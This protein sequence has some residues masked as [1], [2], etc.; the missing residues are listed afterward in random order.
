[1]RPRYLLFVSELGTDCG[2]ADRIALRTGFKVALA[3]RGFTALVNEGC[4]CLPVANGGCVLGTLFPRHGSA[5]RLD[6]IEPAAARAI[7]ES[8]GDDLVRKFWGGYVAAINGPNSVR[9]IRDV[10][11]ALPCY[12]ANGD[13]YLVFA[14]DA[15]LLTDTG[16]ARADIDWSALA[17]HFYAA[18][19]PAASTVIADVRELLPGFA[20]DFP[21]AIAGQRPCWSPWDHVDAD[22][23]DL[24]L[25]AEHLERTVT[26]CAAAWTSGRG[27]LLLSCSGGL[28]S[29]II[30]A[31][32]A[33]SGADAVCLTM[34]GDDPSGD[35]RPYAR[36]LCKHLSLPLLECRYRLEDID[37]EEPLGAHLP[38]PTD[39]SHA[40]SYER[41]HLRA[42]RELGAAAF[43]TGN[44]GDS[45]FG[46]SQ[47]AA[48]I[49][50]RYL[51]EGLGEG[52]AATLRDVCRQTGCGVLKAALMAFRSACGPGAY[53][54]R[55]DGMF[56]DPDVAASLDSA[57]LDHPWLHAPANALPGKAAHIASILRIQPCLEPTRA[58][59]LPVI[60]PLMS[61]PVI[62]ACLAIPSWV[63]RAGGRDRALARCAF[64][65]RLPAA[66][67]KR[68]VKG[69]PDGF[70]AR[71]LEHFRA[72]IRD[73][74]L[75]GQLARHGIVDRTA[76]ERALDSERPGAGE[77][78]ARILEFVAAEAWIECWR[79][80]KSLALEPAA[81]G[82][83]WHA[84]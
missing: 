11:G 53:R 69:G 2:L 35:E 41:A 80:R 57:V 22:G 75:D 40:L 54:C 43:V 76:L 15:E 8:S 61:Q 56:L 37:I 62:E 3:G 20:I 5:H 24:R 52:V 48:A 26:D 60:N 7:L 50:D 14:S 68:R 47:S 83:P 13:G 29:S 36:A 42:A 64:A 71:V 6:A 58:R 1:L 78:R 70:A 66:I 23:N 19:V 59:H 79:S 74:L 49:A 4:G 77:Q 27:R 55:P 51:T 17:A 63:W 38:R 31:V 44:G 21:T 30:A 72:S 16:L 82:S 65:D 45:V 84:D 46:Y 25:A 12:F 73:R 18:G 10:S 39:R 33:Q 67:L 9:I 32:L 81:S 34:Y 28:D